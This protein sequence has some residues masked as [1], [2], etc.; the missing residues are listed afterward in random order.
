VIV[1]VPFVIV[2]VA[3][4]EAMSCGAPLLRTQR[5]WSPF[6]AIVVLSIVS[7]AVPLPA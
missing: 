3:A 7:V 6:I 5:N 4:V 2:S 1:A